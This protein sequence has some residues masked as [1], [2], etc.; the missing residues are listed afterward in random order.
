[1]LI[2]R[3]TM[4]D[5]IYSDSASPDVS[6]M[7]P[8]IRKKEK[9]SILGDRERARGTYREFVIFNREQVYPEY[10]VIYKRKAA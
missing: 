9:D 10:I 7:M 1:M 2:C 5:W 6:A 3:V 8:Q 4:G